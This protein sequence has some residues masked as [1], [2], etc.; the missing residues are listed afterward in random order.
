MATSEGS[1]DIWD[2]PIPGSIVIR[3]GDLPKGSPEEEERDRQALE[4]WEEEEMFR[5]DI[6]MWEAED[7]LRDLDDD[8]AYKLVM[9]ALGKSDLGYC[10]DD[11]NEDDW[12]DQ[13]EPY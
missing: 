3:G 12:P 11:L 4:D 10:I 9:V 6:E 7:R 8:P 2:N 5:Q 1:L 13:E